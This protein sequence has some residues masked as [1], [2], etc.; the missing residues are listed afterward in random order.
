M[1]IGKRSAPSSQGACLRGCRSKGDGETVMIAVWTLVVVVVAA[2]IATGAWRWTFAPFR[3]PVR[4]M[5]VAELGLT[6]PTEHVERIDSVL[7][8][9]AGGFNAMIAA[10]AVTTWQNYCRQL[11][12]L[13]RPFAQEGAA[14]GYTVRQLFRFDARAFEHTIVNQH[15][16]FRYLHYVGVGFWSGM[17]HHDPQKLH[18]VTAHLDPLYRYLSYDGYGFKHGFFDYPQ[19]HAGLAPLD[20][21]DG[22]ARHAAYQGVGRALFFY[23]MGSSDTLIAH[24]NGLGEY[25]LDAAGGIG[26]ASVFIFHDRL[27]V[28]LDL[29]TRWP[30]AWHP[31]VHLGMC[32][33]LKARAINDPDQFVRDVQSQPRA[34]QQ[35][36]HASLEQCD[37][38]EARLRADRAPDG[39]QRWRTQVRD[40][41]T[42]HIEYPLAAF[43]QAGARTPQ[44]EAAIT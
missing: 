28:A 29:A 19:D 2:L 18:Q 1:A 40:W 4:K 9:F 6:V 36:I 25:A 17:R 3:I 21:L 37:R 41:M 38:V 16:G 8:A 39:Y 35:A 11:P 14:M 24:I 33:G 27:D 12:S 32:F 43:Q 42:E 5:T 13:C 23:H 15:P 34:V 20:R 30:E 44:P 7:A 10:P 31:E 26:L 22:Y